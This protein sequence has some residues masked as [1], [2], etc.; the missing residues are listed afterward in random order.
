MKII[1]YDPGY[2][3]NKGC[4]ISNGKEKS[5][6][7]KS[8][9]ASGAVRTSGVSLGTMG[10]RRDN[11]P[12]A[13]SFDGAV[14][15]VGQGVLSYSRL[16]MERMDKGR[17]DDTAPNRAMFYDTVY[18]LLGPGKHELTVIVGVPISALETSEQARTTRDNVRSWM[19]DEHRA[20]VQGN[21]LVLNIERVGVLAQPVGAFF[22]WGLNNVGQWVRSPQDLQ[23]PVGVCDIG[24]NTLDLLGVQGGQVDDRFT[25][26]ANWGMRR[27]AQTLIASLHDEY[28]ITIG[29]HEADALLRQDRPILGV[30]GGSVD[31][32]PLVNTALETQATLALQFIEQNWDDGNQ[33]SYILFTGGG[34]E[35]LR[36]HLTRHYTHGVIMANPLIANS[37]GLAR[38]GARM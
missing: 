8:V 22:A 36:S 12:D 1:S 24:F 30:R 5:V 14:Y 15:Q 26:G 17:F 4:C 34:A 16:I 33:F 19:Q 21:E 11:R 27:A 13:V 32:M 28:D 18:H 6:I 38:Y 31:A 3:H 10:K 20:T 23:L 7:V 37:L 29:L 9:V 35:V 2:G 25:A